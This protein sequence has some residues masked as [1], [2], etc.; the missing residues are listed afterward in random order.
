MTVYGDMQQSSK[1]HGSTCQLLQWGYNA[2]VCVCVRV[3]VCVC[4][5]VFMWS[6]CTENGC[7]H[8]VHVCHIRCMN[9]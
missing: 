6:E 5:C 3:C 9:K 7:M 2:P 1:A 4:V 8:I